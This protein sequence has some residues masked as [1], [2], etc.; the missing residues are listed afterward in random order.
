MKKYELIKHLEEEATKLT[1]IK[2]ID[3]YEYQSLSYEKR[4]A[5]HGKGLQKRNNLFKSNRRVI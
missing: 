1:G 3:D 2:P 5:S 4:T